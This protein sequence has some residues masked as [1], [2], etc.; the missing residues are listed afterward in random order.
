MKYLGVKGDSH[1]HVLVFVALVMG[2]ESV[3]DDSDVRGIVIVNDGN[4][5]I[6][7]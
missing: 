1:R 6:G 4:L 3:C 2:K 7:C 5:L